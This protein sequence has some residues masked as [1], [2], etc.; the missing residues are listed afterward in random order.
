MCP[1]ELFTDRASAGKFLAH[2]LERFETEHPVVVALPRG[3]VPVAYEVACALEAPLD[4]LVVRKIG[5][6]GRPELG[7]GAVAEGPEVVLTPVRARIGV[8]GEEVARL[9]NA[10]QIEVAERVRTLRGSLPPMD[11]TGRTVILVDDG[12]ATGGT[13][14]AA[15]RALRRRGPRRLVLATPIASRSAVETL[16]E[17]ADEIVCPHVKS[18]LGS[19]GLWYEDFSQ[20]TDDEV[21]DL[22]ARS[23]ARPP[24]RRRTPGISCEAVRI[25]CDGAVLEGDLCLPDDAIGVVIFAHGSGSGRSSPRNLEVAQKL[26]GAG[27]GTLLLDLLTPEER[28]V[29][30]TTRKL[31]FDVRMLADRLVAATDWVWR[32]P[33]CA[34]VPVGYFGAST[35]AAAALVAAV[36]CA[37]VVRA[38][39]S[40]GGRPDLAAHAL[41]DVE[42][43]T[44]L[45]V[46]GEDREVLRLNREAAKALRCPKALEIVPGA[47]HLF[48]EPGALE[49]VA[50]ASTAW[51]LRH[52]RRGGAV[53]A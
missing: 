29:D 6:P 15:L 38:V 21:T 32:R 9:V 24:K 51:F 2:E 5:A 18:P 46:G 43:P 37:N 52:F 1:E 42:A 53:A 10:A 50:R 19:V 20:T 16:A 47:T 27:I 7:I 3:G 30:A 36:D 22:L 4:I 8:S 31:R 11:L 26:N 44:L 49:Q 41:G 14:L 33:G 23:R 39:V 48:P 45:V 12:I 34:H 17:A 13:V 25:A 35:G 40:R 28:R